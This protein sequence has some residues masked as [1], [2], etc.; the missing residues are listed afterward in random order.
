MKG[1]DHM[2]LESSEN[3]REKPILVKEIQATTN[4]QNQLQA[5]TNEKLQKPLRF[6]ERRIV[7]SRI[8]DSF[9]FKHDQ[10]CRFLI[11]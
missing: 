3:I 5:Y 10:H 8:I 9:F 6:G 11:N 7:Q 2:T 4:A 1:H